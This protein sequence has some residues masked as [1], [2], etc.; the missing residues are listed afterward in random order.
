MSMRS[1]SAFKGKFFVKEVHHFGNSRQ[2]D[3]ESWATAY[4]AV[5]VG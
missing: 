4:T 5:A 2:P 3:A 1:S